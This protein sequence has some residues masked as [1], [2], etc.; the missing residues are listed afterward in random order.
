[1]WSK[2]YRVFQTYERFDPREQLHRR[3]CAK[4]Q[5]DWQIGDPVYF[6]RELGELLEHEPLRSGF[7][8]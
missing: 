2:L 1:M 4:F 5:H 6:R 8:T 3:I 7:G